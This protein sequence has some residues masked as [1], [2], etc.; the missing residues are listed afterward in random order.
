MMD[1]TAITY[2]MMVTE[3]RDVKIILRR[4]LIQS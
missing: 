2:H 1:Q 3:M 4:E